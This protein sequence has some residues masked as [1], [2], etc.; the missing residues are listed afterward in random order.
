[1][2][3]AELYPHKDGG[4]R[5]SVDRCDHGTTPTGFTQ[6]GPED[7]GIVAGL[8][9]NWQCLIDEMQSVYGNVA[10]SLLP[11]PGVLG[12]DLYSVDIPALAQVTPKLSWP[13]VRLDLPSSL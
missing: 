13:T 8:F 12:E 11:G 2:I 7:L 5:L 10:V 4:F 3:Y 6:E 1:M 9:L